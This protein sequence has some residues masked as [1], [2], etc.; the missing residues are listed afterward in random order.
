MPLTDRQLKTKL[1]SFLT[2]F[3]NTVAKTR[4]ND[5]PK[6]I[7]LDRT[8][9]YSRVFIPWKKVK[10]NSITFEQLQSFS[11]GFTNQT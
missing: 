9:R 11:G 6:N 4:Q 7:W 5:I 3:S 2:K 1:N 8:A 10:A